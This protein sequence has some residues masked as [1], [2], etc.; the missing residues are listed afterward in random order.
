[1]SIVAAWF[2][3]SLMGRYVMVGLAVL[4]ALVW[5]ERRDVARGRRDALEGVRSDDAQT[6][7]DIRDDVRRGRIGGVR[8][9]AIRYRD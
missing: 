6:A 5:K 3:N 7:K 1:M 4:A 8:T 2:A 9:E